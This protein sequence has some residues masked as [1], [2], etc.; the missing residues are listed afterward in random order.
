MKRYLED[1]RL[2]DRE[3]LKKY[4]IIFEGFDTYHVTEIEE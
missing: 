3:N 4:V 1:K 2:S